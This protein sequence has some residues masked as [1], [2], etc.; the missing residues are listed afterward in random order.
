[1]IVAVTATVVTF[2]TVKDPM[3]PVPLAAKP[4]LVVLF[5]QAYVVVPP[6]RV[7]P[8]VTKVLPPLQTT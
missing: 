4:M 7:V 2:V 8:N 3:L 1:V 5:V 6:V